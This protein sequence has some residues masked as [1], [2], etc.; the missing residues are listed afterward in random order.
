MNYFCSWELARV[1][2]RAD[3][4]DLSANALW[5]V[6]VKASDVIWAK[7][8]KCCMPRVITRGCDTTAFDGDS[9]PYTG[10]NAI[11]VLVCNIE[12]SCWG[13]NSTRSDAGAQ[14]FS[15][16]QRVLD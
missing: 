13:E 10:A 14:D 8:G 11:A 4:A 9:E 12:L 7:Q 6:V 5:L 1:L 16:D 15:F 3:E 2:S